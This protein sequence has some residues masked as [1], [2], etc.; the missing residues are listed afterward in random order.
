MY[1]FITVSK[2]YIIE[3]MADMHT[4]TNGRTQNDIIIHYNLHHVQV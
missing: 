2:Q 4:K 1:G 3:C